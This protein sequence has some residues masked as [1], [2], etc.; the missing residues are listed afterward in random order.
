[1]TAITECLIIN[2]TE[3]IRGLNDDC[4][5]CNDLIKFLLST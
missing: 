5:S 1:M 2:E 4:N 3:E